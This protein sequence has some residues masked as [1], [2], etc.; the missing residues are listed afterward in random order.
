ML[1]APYVSYLVER[2]TGP[3]L[4]PYLIALDAVEVWAIVRGAI[5]YRTLVI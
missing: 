5:R 4:A 1:A 3:L 2:R